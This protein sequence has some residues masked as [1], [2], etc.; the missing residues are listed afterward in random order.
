MLSSTSRRPARFNSRQHA[1]MASSREA[2]NA[3]A[4]TVAASC[5]IVLSLCTSPRAYSVIAALVAPRCKLGSDD[6]AR[7]MEQTGLSKIWPP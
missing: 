3:V 2:A 7:T 6:L 1:T 5:T 4:V